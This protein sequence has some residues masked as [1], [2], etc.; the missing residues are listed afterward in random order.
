MTETKQE[1]KKGTVGQAFN[2]PIESTYEEMV[3]NAEEMLI[4]YPHPDEELHKIIRQL[5]RFMQ[6]FGVKKLKI[7]K[8]EG[9]SYLD[10]E[11]QKSEW[12]YTG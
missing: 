8:S 6:V 3:K 1:S 12:N 2:P 9:A 7:E 10:V 11:Y 4:K 5:N